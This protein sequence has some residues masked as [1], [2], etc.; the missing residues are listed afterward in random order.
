M[1]ARVTLVSY[2]TPDT[3]SWEQVKDTPG[4]YCVA[5]SPIPDLRIVVISSIVGPLYVG[6]SKIEPASR[7][8]WE[9]RRYRRTEETMS[10]EFIPKT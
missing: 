9:A 4:I 5:E 10:I 8:V 1:F 6:Y 2:P 7:S 3:L